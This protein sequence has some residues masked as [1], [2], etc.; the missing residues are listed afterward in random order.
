MLNIR[1]L[2]DQKEP[3]MLNKG[4]EI[5]DFVY[6]TKDADTFARGKMLV[7]NY[8]VDNSLSPSDDEYSVIDDPM[9]ISLG[10]Y[11]DNTKYQLNGLAHQLE[12]LGFFGKSVQYA[13]VRFNSDFARCFNA[14]VSNT[15]NIT[16][17]GSVDWNYVDADLYSS[18]HRPN[19][20]KEYYALYESLAIQYE[21]SNGI[22][23]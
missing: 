8:I 10:S 4:F 15:D 6:R 17:D 9:Q 2:G 14:A 13:P 12:K 7:H 11:A 3:T 21:L 18:D 20:D 22:I 23:Q 16:E 5:S 19:S 1:I